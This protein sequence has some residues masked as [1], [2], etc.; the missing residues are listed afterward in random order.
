[1]KIIFL[2]QEIIKIG[3]RCFCNCY[4]LKTL[5]YPRAYID[6]TQLSKLGYSI[7]AVF[8]FKANGKEHSL[9]RK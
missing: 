3:I 9:E 5:L 2:Y 7:D 8:E 1:M 6:R 4:S